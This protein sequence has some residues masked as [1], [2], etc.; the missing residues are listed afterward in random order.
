MITIPNITRSH[1]NGY[2]PPLCADPAPVTDRD[3][4]QPSRPPANPEPIRAGNT[5]PARPA[6]MT[7]ILTRPN[8]FAPHPGEDLD[9]E[10]LG[11][12]FPASTAPENDAILQPPKPQ[13]TLSAKILNLAQERDAVP[14]AAD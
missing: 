8:D 1:R 6:T 2:H 5:R 10:D 11:Q 12:A 3:Q 7:R 9:R 14:E 4:P 13:I